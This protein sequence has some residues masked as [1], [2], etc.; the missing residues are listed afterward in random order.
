MSKAIAMVLLLI[1]CLCF[2]VGCSTGSG[3]Q[4]KGS[5]VGLQQGLNV[6]GGGNERATVKIRGRYGPNGEVPN[7]LAAPLLEQ[8]GSR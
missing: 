2:F 1:V 3:T 7:F 8:G 4:L 5:S 6:G